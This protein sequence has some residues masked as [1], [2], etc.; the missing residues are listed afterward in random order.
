[1]TFLVRWSPGNT[2]ESLGD[3]V[4]FLS[5]NRPPM[6]HEC[7][8][9]VVFCEHH[10][11]FVFYICDRHISPIP[12]INT[13]LILTYFLY[14]TYH[15]ICMIGPLLKW[16]YHQLSNVE[17]P[18]G[19]HCWNTYLCWVGSLRFICGSGT[20]R[21]YL[22]M[23]GPQMGSGVLPIVRMLQWWSRRWPPWDAPHRQKVTL[24]ILSLRVHALPLR[25][26]PMPAVR[27]DLNGGLPMCITFISGI[28]GCCILVFSF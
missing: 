8:I 6:A 22:R 27:Y 24:C 4:I 25:V 17:R 19:G 16:T 12:T 15:Y 13:A 14:D 3:R 10:I 28:Y 2:I 9:W 5:H 23:S 26:A 7:D 21:F 11:R 18:P 1:M 20:R